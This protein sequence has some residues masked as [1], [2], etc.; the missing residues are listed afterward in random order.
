MRRI[1][2]TTKAVDL[3]GA[4]KHG[5]KNG[6]SALAI[7][8]TKL[9]AEWFNAIQEELANFIE[10]SGQSLNSADNTQ[11]SK[12][13]SAATKA[14]GLGQYADFRT[15]AYVTG[16]P[17]ALYGK[18][19]AFGFA[20]GGPAGLAI[21]GLTGINYGC[22][23]VD[24]QYSDATGLSAITR[25]FKTGTR[26]F[27]QSAASASAWGAWAEQATLSRANTWTAKQTGTD[28][29]LSGVVNVN[30]S[31]STG[32]GAALNA[33]STGAVG[34][35]GGAFYNSGSGGTACGGLAV[36]VGNNACPL[37]GF[38]SGAAGVGSITTNGTSTTYG[39]T[40][41]Y[42]LKY[43]DRPMSGA[44]DRIMQL[45]PKFYKWAVDG[46]D[47]EGFFAHELQAVFPGAVNGEKDAMSSVYEDGVVVGETPNYQSVDYSK[48]V[49]ALV[50]AMQELKRELD[51]AAARITVLEGA[52]K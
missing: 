10:G 45:T 25:T 21:P 16:A 13:L 1:D 20:D 9:N 29:D 35:W 2:T 11:L 4:G 44:L 14:F 17:S 28:F 33:S 22:L 5:F 31:L 43:N 32:I 23:F 6:D 19:A 8:A 24:S 36:K 27:I 26:I 41:D 39:T 18:G 37:I 12:A 38:Y 49:P 47:G 51:A 7:L 30:Y 48:I 52:G 15:S 46:G 42:R 40:S 34:I 50:S 3:F